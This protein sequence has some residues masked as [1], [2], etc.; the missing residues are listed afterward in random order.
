M[1]HLE[2]EFLKKFIT[3]QGKILPRS[4]TGLSINEQKIMC[5]SIKQARLLG[6]L[7]FSLNESAQSSFISTYLTTSSQK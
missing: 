4:I 5:S 3:E 2:L 6:L 1:N 7:H